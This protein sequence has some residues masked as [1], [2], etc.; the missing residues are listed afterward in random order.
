VASGVH[1][2]SVK[3]KGFDDWVKKLNVTAGS[4]HLTADLDTIKVAQ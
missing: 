3:K 2:I 4:I 1:D